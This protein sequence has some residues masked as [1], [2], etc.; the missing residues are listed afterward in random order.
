MSNSS[1]HF[2]HITD[3]KLPTYIYETFLIDM[4]SEIEEMLLNGDA[5]ESPMTSSIHENAVDLFLGGL[6][7]WGAMSSIRDRMK[8]YRSAL[9]NGIGT[10]EQLRLYNE[11]E[12]AFSARMN[13]SAAVYLVVGSGGSNP[14]TGNRS[15]VM[16]PSGVTHDSLFSVHI[17]KEIFEQKLSKLESNQRA[18]SA[19]LEVIAELYMMEGNFSQSLKMFIMLGA[20]NSSGQLSSIENM[21]VKSVF[22]PE[23]QYVDPPY[24]DRYKHVLTL[25]ETNELHRVL[26]DTDNEGTLPPLVA[27]TCLVG[28]Q[29]AGR[30]IIDH[31]ILPESEDVS[32]G[33][34][35]MS[36]P[37][38]MVANQLE[39][40]PKLLLWFLHSVISFKPEIYVK[41]P[42]TAVPSPAV[43]S[44]HQIHFELYI[45]FADRT[46]KSERKLSEVP[47]F[48]EI[49]KE[50]A[51][52]RFLKVCV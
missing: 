50:S 48:D 29:D 28:L 12:S 35:I 2:A 18:K 33:A 46:N 44:L 10:K 43:T 8:L 25:V 14:E 17:I 42:N 20:Q 16:L 9:N 34:S 40:Y 22:Q 15:S 30:F 21:A 7:A 36:F 31:C 5:E 11:A 24:H 47:S 38:D 41:F 52:L 23:A 6:R 51:L 3:P 49:H 26:L 1:L 32:S 13:Q 39:D 27:F 19:I 4:F 45:K 37:L